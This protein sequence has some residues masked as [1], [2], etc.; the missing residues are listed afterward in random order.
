MYDNTQ[1]RLLKLQDWLAT[2]E[3]EPDAIIEASQC[4]G[5]TAD[6]KPRPERVRKLHLRTITRVHYSTWATQRTGPVRRLSTV[7]HRYRAQIAIPRS[8]IKSGQLTEAGESETPA[9]RES[10]CTAL[11]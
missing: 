2:I 7:C 9:L 6:E 5:S 3:R 10:R 11:F 4:N 1:D 8:G